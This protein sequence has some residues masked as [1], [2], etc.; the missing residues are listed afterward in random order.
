[1]RVARAS[2]EMG[3]LPPFPT[4]SHRTITTMVQAEAGFSIVGLSISLLALGYD[5][6]M[7]VPPSERACVCVVSNYCL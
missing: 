1:V 2:G 4:L 7:S 6:I 3:N 5:H